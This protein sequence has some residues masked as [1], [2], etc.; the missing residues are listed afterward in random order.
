[1][2]V[3][4]IKE[5][6]APTAPKPV[7]QRASAILEI[8]NGIGKGQVAKIDPDGGSVRGLKTSFGRVASGRGMK[9]KTWSVPG[10]P[11][12]YVKKV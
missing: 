11:A 10:D 2:K 4:Y 7:S 12:V 8:I 1:M 3:E 9:V 6:E 5:S